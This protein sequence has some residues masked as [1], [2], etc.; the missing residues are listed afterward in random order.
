MR[1]YNTALLQYNKALF[2]I[3]NDLNENKAAKLRPRAGSGC[4]GFIPVGASRAHVAS[5][6]VVREHVFE[7]VA[8]C[9]R[10]AS[11]RAPG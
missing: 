9:V 3:N 4:A 8:R 5:A 7:P 11:L 1:P 2:K 6:G 10:P